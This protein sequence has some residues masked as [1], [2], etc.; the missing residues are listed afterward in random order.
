M[1]DRDAEF[2]AFYKELRIIDQRRF[3]D[4]RR[5][6]Y[7][8]AHR[9]AIAV[10]NTLLALAALAGVAGQ[11]AA[12]PGRALSGVVAAVLAALAGAVTAFEALIGFAP[13]TKL[14]D[15]AALNLAEAEIDWDSADPDSDLV[16]D[17]ERVEQIFH[18]E[19][20]QWGQLV[21]QGT[22][23]GAPVADADGH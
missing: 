9:Q 10:R 19:N 18:T 3:Y 7:E 14:Y 6:E 23:R 17:V 20:G 1:T 22:S 2:R 16:A 4:D 15:D 11:F 21:R 8:Q 12:G 5:R 13:L